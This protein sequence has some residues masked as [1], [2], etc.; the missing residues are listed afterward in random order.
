MGYPSWRSGQK[1]LVSWWGAKPYKEGRRHYLGTFSS[2][3]E[4]KEA[5]DKF[6]AE[7]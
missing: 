3:A 4:A 5:V 1:S 6:W 2:E 7:A